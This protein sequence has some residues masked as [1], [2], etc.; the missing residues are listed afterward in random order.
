MLPKS[1]EAFLAPMLAMAGAQFPR[2]CG[3]CRRSYADF[4]EFV[5]E[6]KPI[7]APTLGIGA[8]LD[9]IGMVS[10]TNCAC[11]STL[12]LFCSD[13]EGEMHSLFMLALE[14]EAQASGRPLI[15]V[16]LAVR[17]EVR[18]RAARTRP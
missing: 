18:R 2:D 12:V 8:A 10:W 14:A 13:T 11:G 4:A 6:T 17:T 1:L 7:G 15:E 16:A 3:S 5:R 9:P